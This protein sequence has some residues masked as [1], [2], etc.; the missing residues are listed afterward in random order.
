MKGASGS[1]E[2]VGLRIGPEALSGEGGRAIRS[3]SVFAQCRRRGP[4]TA[5]MGTAADR[6]FARA[7]HW[8]LSRGVQSWG[9]LLELVWN[10]HEFGILCVCKIEYLSRPFG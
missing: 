2:A 8:A 7:R 10:F 4:R 6:M 5:R 3:R 9:E 1:F